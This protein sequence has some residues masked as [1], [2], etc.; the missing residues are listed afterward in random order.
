M[1]WSIVAG[2][3]KETRSLKRYMTISIFSPPVCSGFTMSA[4]T[5][6]PEAD[7]AW[8]LSLSELNG[9]KERERER[10]RERES[11]SE[12]ESEQE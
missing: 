9:E 4:G 12:S 8:K 10:E 6:R 11:E 3:E 7:I 2:S 5:N 1:F